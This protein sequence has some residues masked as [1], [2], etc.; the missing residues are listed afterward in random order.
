MKKELMIY[1]AI[2]ILSAFVIHSDLFTDPL[3]RFE[4]MSERANYYH[5]FLF[6]LV[7]YMV[8]GLGRLLVIGIKKL[9][10]H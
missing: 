9:T 6:A 5:P 4:I 10:R 1:V 3:K 7:I 2:I 8:I